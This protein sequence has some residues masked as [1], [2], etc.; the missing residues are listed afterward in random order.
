MFQPLRQL[1]T[2]IKYIDV[3]QIY[4]INV[5]SRGETRRITHDLFFE[6]YF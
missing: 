3:L 4:L 6:G 2:D 1:K 5:I